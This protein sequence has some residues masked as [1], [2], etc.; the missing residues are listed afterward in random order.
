MARMYEKKH[1]FPGNIMH[2]S[3][4]KHQE[5]QHECPVCGEVG[6]WL[7]GGNSGEIVSSQNVGEDAARR[8]FEPVMNWLSLFW[9]TLIFK[10]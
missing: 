6:H 7:P 4:A 2:Q 5:A 10:W 3:I 1:A 8:V 9:N